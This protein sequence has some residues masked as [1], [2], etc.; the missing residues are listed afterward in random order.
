MVTFEHFWTFEHS[1]VS[2]YYHSFQ[3]LFSYRKGIGGIY[4]FSIQQFKFFNFVRVRADF[5]LLLPCFRKKC[6]EDLMSDYQNQLTS[7][8]YE[9]DWLSQISLNRNQSQVIYSA[10]LLYT[11]LLINLFRWYRWVTWSIS[12]NIWNKWKNLSSRKMIQKA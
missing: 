2:C 8:H 10:I 3:S 5:M 6:V 9:S 4:L 12:F 1:N 11:N 7:N